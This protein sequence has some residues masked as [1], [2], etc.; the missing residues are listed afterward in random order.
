MRHLE[1]LKEQEK[2]QEAREAAL[3]RKLEEEAKKKTYKTAKIQTERVEEFERSESS[4][5]Y[6]AP[7]TPTEK[8]SEED[9]KEFEYDAASDFVDK[10][11]LMGAK[12]QTENAAIGDDKPVVMEQESSEDLEYQAPPD[13]DDFMGMTEKEYVKYQQEQQRL[14]WFEKQEAKKNFRDVVIQAEVVDLGQ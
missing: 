14:S 8:I 11:I 1:I 6:V 4:D 2:E 13:S 9:S 5:E 10:H 7:P 3:K 12:K